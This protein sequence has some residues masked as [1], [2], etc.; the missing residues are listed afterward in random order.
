MDMRD[1]PGYVGLLSAQLVLH[2]MC[3][4]GN[5][6]KPRL[7]LGCY[8]R[9][10]NG[11]HNIG[12]LRSKL[13]IELRTEQRTNNTHDTDNHEQASQFS[14]TRLAFFLPN[15]RCLAHFATFL[16]HIAWHHRLRPLSIGSL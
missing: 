2:A 3:S 9:P 13:T 12:E 6:E 15:R 14:T 5:P 11:A 1:S 8:L 10:K 16:L 7:D 4:I